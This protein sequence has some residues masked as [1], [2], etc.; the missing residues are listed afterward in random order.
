MVFLTLLLLR[1]GEPEF[2]I[3]ILPPKYRP[4]RASAREAL[5]VRAMGNIECTLLGGSES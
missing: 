1:V 4:S 5:G 3:E 2:R